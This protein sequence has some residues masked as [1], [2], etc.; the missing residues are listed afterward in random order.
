MTGFRRAGRTRLA[1]ALL[2][3]AT[4]SACDD[5]FLA[6]IPGT[7]QYIAAQEAAAQAAQEEADWAVA[8]ASVDCKLVSERQYLPVELQTGLTRERVQEILAAKIT[9]GE[10]VVRADGG[11]DYTGGPC[12]PEVPATA[13]APAAQVPA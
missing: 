4:L 13:E 12:A 11:Y 10:A 2:A 5:A 9:A 3:V 7:D 1:M 6:T 8:V